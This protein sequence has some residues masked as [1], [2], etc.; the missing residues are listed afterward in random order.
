MEKSKVIEKLFEHIVVYSYLILP[1]LYLLIRNKKRDGA[2]LAVYGIVIYLLLFFYSE[3]PPEFRKVYHSIFT[4]FEYS[5]F[6]LIFYFN[7][8]T[9]RYRKIIPALSIFFVIFQIIHF[10]LTSA[11]SRIDSIP[12]GVESIIIFIYIFLFFLENLNNPGVGYIYNHHCFWISV[13]LLLYLG[14]SFFIYILGTTFSEE[15]FNKY[16]YL[17]YIA[18]TIKTLLFAVSFIF[19]AKK[20]HNDSNHKA[21]SVPYLDM[22]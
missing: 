6:A 8:E 1:L 9:P 19:L 14:G 21:A 7:L 2:I 10:V 3:F 11:D 20:P 13:G 22:S 4:F 12:I 16:W 5:F 15:E 17:N 18:D